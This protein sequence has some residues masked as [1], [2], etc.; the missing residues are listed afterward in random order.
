ML[1][2]YS[3]AARHA[4]CK[5]ISRRGFFTLPELELPP[6]LNTHER[7]PFQLP[8]VIPLEGE[9]LEAMFNS[10]KY[11]SQVTFVAV[12]LALTATFASAQVSTSG[13][14]AVSGTVSKFVELHSGGAVT[15]AGNSGGGVTLDGLNGQALNV[16]VDLGELGPANAASFVTATVPLKLRSNTNYILSMSASILSSGSS[17]S[18]IGVADIGFGLGTISRPSTGPISIGVASGT[19]TDNTSGDP[20]NAANGGVN[21]T[22]GRF[23]YTAA[24]SHLGAFSSSTTVL[25]GPRI[26][27]AVPRANGNGLSVPAIF[28]VKPQF[29]ENGTMTATANFTIAA[30]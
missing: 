17:T 13:T 25:S 4:D 8:I 5:S 30:P 23:E 1:V 16:A 14:V 15:L 2:A 21:A 12:L 28:S 27:N 20:T 29:Y 24:R 9:M 6:T 18:K 11:L 19:D 7:T 22:T 10:L 3:L 26:L